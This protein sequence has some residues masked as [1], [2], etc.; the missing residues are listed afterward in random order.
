MNLKDEIWM[1]K[2][3][4]KN[5]RNNILNKNRKERWPFRNVASKAVVCIIFS[6]IRALTDCTRR[7]GLRKYANSKDKRDIVENNIFTE[8]HLDSA[9]IRTIQYVWKITRFVFLCF[10]RRRHLTCVNF[11][12]YVHSLVYYEFFTGKKAISRTSDNDE[13]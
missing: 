8:R 12:G 3:K 4:K 10:L 13:K 9:T 11:I 5:E 2:E 6:L 1:E 7:E